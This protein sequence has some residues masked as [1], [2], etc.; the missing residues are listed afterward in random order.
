MIGQTTTEERSTR[1]IAAV[2]DLSQARTNQEV[3]DIVRHAA[4]RLLDA[5]GATFV[6][7]DNGDCYYVDEDAI[8]PLWKG[9]RFPMESCISGWAMN[10]REPVVIPDIYVDERIPLDAYRVTFVK[11]LVMVPIRQASPVGAVGIYWD[12]EYEATPEEVALAQALADTTA[13]ALENIE[14]IEG[15]EQ[16]VEERTAALDEANRKLSEISITDELTGLYNRRGFFNFASH[17]LGVARHQGNMCHLAFLDIDGLKTINDTLGHK[18][19]DQAIKEFAGLLREVVD[20][21][22]VAARLGGDEFVALIPAPTDADAVVQRL[23]RMLQSRNARV[24]ADFALSVSVGLVDCS[25]NSLD[26]ALRCADEVM[27]R[28]KTAG[29]RRRAPVARQS[30][31]A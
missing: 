22:A 29:T 16:K 8:S 3:R 24:G 20:E 7:R 21:T 19:G 30:P 17:E 28:A 1:L 4:R 13:V 2:Q 31:R 18:F 27:Y 6:L 14:L 25:D 26:D 5:D 15:L 12:H 9:L 10:H 23:E 11:S